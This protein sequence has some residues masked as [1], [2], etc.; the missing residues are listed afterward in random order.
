MSVVF[1][2]CGSPLACGRTQTATVCHYSGS[3]QNPE[4]IIPVRH[5]RRAGARRWQYVGSMPGRR[6]ARHRTD[7]L[8]ASPGGA[9]TALPLPR[10]FLARG[11]QDRLSC[12]SNPRVSRS[13]WQDPS[14]SRI[15]SDPAFLCRMHQGSVCFQMKTVSDSI[16]VFLSLRFV[17]LI[18]NRRASS[19]SIAARN[20]DVPAMGRCKEV[21]ATCR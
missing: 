11:K 13:M 6:R 9:P 21:I 2:A 3:P 17:C 5:E 7:V 10:T 19:T 18:G 1:L 16:A 4:K 20:R 14:G 12:S 8:P 15:V